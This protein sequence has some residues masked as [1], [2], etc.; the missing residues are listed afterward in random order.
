[1]LT[2]VK[3]LLDQGGVQ[4]YLCGHDHDLQIIQHPAD[5]FA[6]V[7]SGGGGGCRTTAWGAHSKAVATGGGFAVLHVD[8][9]AL[10]AQVV[11]SS[12]SNRGTVL[13]S[14]REMSR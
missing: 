4:A 1:M 9:K 14:K 2:H 3:P 11:D 10:Y 13:I 6:C 7:I 5:A 8:E 12:A